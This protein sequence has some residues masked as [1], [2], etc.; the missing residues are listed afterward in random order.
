[1]KPIPHRE[2]NSYLPILVAFDSEDDS[3]GNVISFD[4]TW[5]HPHTKK[6]EK[7]HTLDPETA[8]HFVRNFRKTC[9]FIANNLEYDIVNL[10]RDTDFSELAEMSYTA[11][12]ISCRIK[13][14]K[15][16][17]VDSYNFFTSS[18]ADMGHSIGL[19]KLPFDPTNPAYAERDPH[20]VLDFVTP[21]REYI[22][23]NYDMDMTNT[24]GGLS[25]KIFLENY[26]TRAYKP[27]NEQIALDAFYGGRCEVFHKGECPPG[28][29]FEA[30]INSEYPSVMTKE[31]PDSDTILPMDTIDARFGVARCTVQSPKNIYIPVL[32]YRMETKL[33]FPLGVFTGTW[34]FA[35]LKAA[36]DRGYKILKIHE[37]YGTDVGCY[38]FKKFVEENYAKRLATE[39]EI[40]KIFLKLLLNNL[41]G[42][43]VTHKDRCI[44]THGEMSRRDKERQEATL[45][46]VY[47]NIYVYKIP[48]NEPPPNTNYIWGAYVT[49]YGRL[50]L[51]ENL[52]KA[53]GTEGTTLAYCDTDSVIGFGNVPD[54]D[55]H[56]TR[57]G[58]LKCKTWD[59]FVAYMPKG[60]ILAKRETSK[61]TGVTKI[62][63][64]GIPQPPHIKE[65]HLELSLENPRMQFLELG[66]ATFKKPV[67]FRQSLVQNEAPNVWKINVKKR[68]PSSVKRREPD[69]VGK[70]FPLWIEEG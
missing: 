24:I 20:I 14:R 45:E 70:T 35:E 31:F 28:P 43:L 12:L 54:L 9:I 37:S 22:I 38:P 30:D 27:F 7:F 2:L 17:F 18:V 64:K 60:Y 50:L 42:K 15:H 3:N 55:F 41:Y 16:R 56:E 66:R 58:A 32:P 69:K 1:M 39:N 34:T 25:M 57:L 44:I 65:Q 5:Y 47:G 53:N 33:I 23:Q 59:K 62:T 67:K 10:Y 19:E 13:G 49:S 11:R 46:N 40:W 4:F 6:R 63:C 61:D 51:L 48:L 21:F 29:I 26:L 36:K 68:N 8:R 52:E